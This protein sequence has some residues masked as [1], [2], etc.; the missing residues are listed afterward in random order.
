MIT[1]N[2]TYLSE[3]I[4]MVSQ[5][6]GYINCFCDKHSS[7]TLLLKKETELLNGKMKQHLDKAP[8]WAFKLLWT[9]PPKRASPEAD[10]VS[11]QQG[12]SGSPVGVPEP[13]SVPRPCFL[14]HW[15]SDAIKRLLSLLQERSGLRA[16]HSTAAEFRS[17]GYIFS[18]FCGDGHTYIC[19]L[20]T[21][22][23]HPEVKCVLEYIRNQ[24]SLRLYLHVM[25]VCRIN[26]GEW[27]DHSE[28]KIYKCVHLHQCPLIF[29]D[30]TPHYVR[31]VNNP[32]KCIC[33]YL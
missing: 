24:H 21:K 12:P 25:N 27:L 22:P 30:Y 19:I 11:Q 9:A 26:K 3:G 1:H 8:D 15:A 29:L 14:T 33:I 6:A 13:H 17:E 18:S 16:F 20:L 5:E 28:L 31:K 32:L 23:D 4:A 10:L 2:R 7:E